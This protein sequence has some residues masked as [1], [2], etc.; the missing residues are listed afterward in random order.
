MIGPAAWQGEGTL[1]IGGRKPEACPPALPQFSVGDFQ[2]EIGSLLCQAMSREMM[3]IIPVAGAGT[4][5]API[6]RVIPKAMFQ[7]VGRDG[8]VR[9]VA[10]WIAR[11]ACAAGCQEICFVCDDG[12]REL[13]ARY[14]DR[15]DGPGRLSYVSGVEPYGFGY[16][17]WS[18]RK[19]LD[20]RDALVMLGDNVYLPHALCPA[21]AA[22]VTA[23][24]AARGGVAMT[25]VQVVGKAAFP[26]VG[27][28][29]GDRPEDVGGGVTL[30]RCRRV[31]EKP[32]PDQAADLAS[33]GLG[34]GQ[35]LAHAGIY[36]FTAQI[37]DCL[38]ELVS[39]RREGGQVGLSEAQQMLLERDPE[40]YWLCRIAGTTLDMGTPENYLTTLNAFAAAGPKK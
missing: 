3:A 21:P 2:L 8:A 29:Q 4:R 23:A 19:L 31:V 20:G 11:E 28:C 22:Q 39:R 40:K 27:V 10:E 35:Y 1:E 38:D 12:Q 32:R 18:A 26:L 16:A 9:P 34:R 6:T 36:A 7:L 30:Y 37:M 15:G 17:V 24:F 25:G 14:F 13:L 33:E 5:L